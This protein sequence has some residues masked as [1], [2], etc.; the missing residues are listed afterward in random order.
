MGSYSLNNQAPPNSNLIKKRRRCEKRLYRCAVRVYAL[1]TALILSFSVIFGQLG[2]TAQAETSIAHGAY[3]SRAETAAADKAAADD[4]ETPSGV[5]QTEAKKAPHPILTADD[6][7]TLLERYYL[8]GKLEPEPLFESFNQVRETLQ[9]SFEDTETC[10]RYL[11]HAKLISLLYV[12]EGNRACKKYD[13]VIREEAPAFLK[14]VVRLPAATKTQKA[15]LYVRYADYLY[16][17][18]A[19][20]SHTFAIASALPVLYRKALLL[21]PD[22]TEAAVKLALLHIFPADQTTSN[23]NGF[24]E[25]QE[26]F[27][28]ELPAA[29]RFNAYLLYSIYYMK[30]YESGKGSAYLQKAATLFPDHM[31]LSH[32]RKNYEKGVFSL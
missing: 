15:A 1:N 9:T 16:T 29:D 10:K 22:N 8:T 13:A 27:L 2:Q 28:E 3:E 7:E 4:T 30:K 24:I 11:E 26:E 25:T 32:V 17:K 20:S 19:V 23:Y 5:L 6:C 14:Q 31:L 12:Y 21:D 18:I